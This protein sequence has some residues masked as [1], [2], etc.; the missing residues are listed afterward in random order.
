MM[1]DGKKKKRII[2]LVILAAFMFGIY[3]FMAYITYSTGMIVPVHETDGTE[4]ELPV[5]DGFKLEDSFICENDVIQGVFLY[6][7]MGDASASGRVSV[8]LCDESGD[9]L[10]EAE[11]TSVSEADGRFIFPDV[12]RGLEGKRLTLKIQ[13]AGFEDGQ[14]VR[15]KCVDTKVPVFGVITQEKDSFFVMENVVYIVLILGVFGTF[16]VVIFRNADRTRMDGA[17]TRTDK[18][19]KKWRMEN[20]YLI[21]GLAMG[22]IFALIIPMMAVPDELVHLRT[23]YDVSDSMMGV[24]EDTLVMRRADAERHYNYTEVTRLDFVREYGDIFSG[25][26]DKELVDTGITVTGNPRFLYYIPALGITIGRLFGCGT[27]LTFLF[28]RLFNMIMFIFAVY[29]AIRKIPFGKGVVFVWALLPMTLQQVSYY[30][31]DTPI[32]ALSIL[33]ISTTLSLAYDREPAK[34]RIQPRVIVLVLSCLL[35]IPCKGHALLPLVV[36]P[37]MLVPKYARDHA[38]TVAR[39]K[40]RIRPWM[41]IVACVVTAVVVVAAGLILY[42]IMG[43]LTAPENINNNYIEWADQNGYTVGY[44][45]R[46]PIRLVMIMV[47]TLWFK[48]DM[49]LQQMMGGL[50]GWLEI[51]IPWMII[52]AFMLVMI[53]AALRR[54]G[55]KTILSVAD[56]VWM[57]LVFAGV[58]ALACAAML[59]YWTP[60]S[61][62]TIEGV[63][64]RYF[65]PGLVLA[66]LTI[67]T[68]KTC[69]S[70][71]A[72][73]YVVMWT[74]LLQ[75][76]TVTAIF[77]NFV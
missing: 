57:L 22:I 68:Q 60:N 24:H 23:A 56:R 18:T 8:A 15:L 40:E 3:G 73:K 36:L 47:Y 52:I 37:C 45:I 67:R 63:Q 20:V 48:G 17:K 5:T 66:M 9:L 50:L 6:F 39:L 64:G 12:L 72:D 61:S 19:E 69:V 7:S 43:R 38:D 1:K 55:E 26:K 62:I 4:Q 77:K 27:T 49:Y 41:K 51:E 46:N 21:A 59:L 16:V 42:R 30:S 25:V 76:M 29:Y 13:C 28:G 58:C 32:L 33:A 11:K 71:D 2:L 54:E 34:T 74:M 70:E 53:Y 10:A 31:P 75:V 35:L 44:F 14:N 65:L